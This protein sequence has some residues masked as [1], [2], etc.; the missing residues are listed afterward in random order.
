MEFEIV[1][2]EDGF[3]FWKKWFNLVTETVLNQEEIII[4]IWNV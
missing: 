3:I 1:N 2:E 4:K